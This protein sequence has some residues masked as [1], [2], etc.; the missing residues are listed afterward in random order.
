MRQLHLVFVEEWF[1]LVAL[2]TSA[3]GDYKVTHDGNAT[4][5]KGQDVTSA[6]VKECAPMQ[7]YDAIKNSEF[8]IQRM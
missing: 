5:I 6:K 4:K 1:V 8:N 2:E 3:N 7:V